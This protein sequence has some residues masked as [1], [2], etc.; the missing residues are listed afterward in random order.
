MTATLNGANVHLVRIDTVND[1]VV[2][3]PSPS[4]RSRARSRAAGHTVWLASGQDTLTRID[5]VASAQDVCRP[6]APPASQPPTVT[7]LWLDSLRMVSSPDRMGPALDFE[8]LLAC[9]IVTGTGTHDRRRGHMD[10]RHAVNDAGCSRLARDLFVL[11]AERAWLGVGTT[12]YSTFDGG[13]L[14]PPFHV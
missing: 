2:G 9:I 4:A 5:L 12:L 6:P 13:R 11:D 8:P 3:R 7:P 1:A 14:D 10:R